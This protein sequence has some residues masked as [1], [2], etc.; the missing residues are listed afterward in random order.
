MARDF[1]KVC[2]NI[3]AVAPEKLAEELE[4]KAVFW[5]P[6][7]RWYNLTKYVHM[8]VDPD[9]SD[10][11]SI[12]VYAELCELSLSEMKSKFQKDGY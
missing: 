6:E 1:T 5:A 2:D 8:Y 7:I 11:Q 4:K 9:S 3:I 12:A 10:P